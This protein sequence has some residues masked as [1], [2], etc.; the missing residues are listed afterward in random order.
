MKSSIYQFSRRHHLLDIS[1]YLVLMIAGVLLL[2]KGAEDQGYYWQWF[3]VPRY[4]YEFDDGRF[5][6]G[7]ILQ[8]L[9]SP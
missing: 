4:I 2:I 3:R 1:A 9:Q 6:A 5:V 8:G 7:P